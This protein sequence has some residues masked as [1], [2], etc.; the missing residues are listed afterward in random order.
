MLLLLVIF[1]GKLFIV[2]KCILKKT[3]ELVISWRDCQN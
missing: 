2:M 3:I 1:D